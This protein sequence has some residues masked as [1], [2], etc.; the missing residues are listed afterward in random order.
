[1]SRIAGDL[2]LSMLD[3]AVE[4]M[5]RSGRRGSVRVQGDSMVPTLHAGQLLAVEFHPDRLRSGDLLLYRKESYLVVHRLLD[6]VRCTDGVRRMRTR[7]DGRNGL[8]PLLDRAN[9][10]GR[11]LALQDHG[12]WWDLRGRWA[13]SYATGLAWHDLFWAGVGQAAYRFDRLRAGGERTT[14]RNRVWALDLWLLRR[15]HGLLF[16]AFHRRTS[17][18]IEGHGD[19]SCAD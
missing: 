17:R 18:P 2:P 7:G 10:V 11:V 13:R 1:M 5:G 14:W 4:L 15:V 3:A 6:R 9:V 19:D 8:D 16:R 12:A